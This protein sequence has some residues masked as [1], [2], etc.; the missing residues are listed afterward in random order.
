[1]LVQLV[2][3]AVDIVVQHQ[4]VLTL[5]FQ[6]LLLQAVAVVLLAIM[7]VAL[8]AL[9]AVVTVDIVQ[10]VVAEH[11]VKVLLVVL[12]LVVDTYLQTKPMLVVE[13]VAQE[14]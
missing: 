12:V 2:E 11:Q 1:V 10:L 8:V 3:L 4:R 13:A 5:H 9:V 6:P 7:L 14:Q